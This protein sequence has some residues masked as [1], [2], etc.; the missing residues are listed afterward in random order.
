V[1]VLISTAASQT[2]VIFPEG[3]TSSDPP[4]CGQLRGG[5]FLW[6]QS[7]TWMKNTADISTNMYNLSLESSLGYN[8]TG[9]YGFDRIALGGIGSGGLT[10]VNQTI[11]GIEY[12]N[13]FLGLFGLNPRFSTFGNSKD[14]IPSFLVNLKTQGLIPSTSWSYTAGNQYRE[15]THDTHSKLCKLRTYIRS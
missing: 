7:T 15:S 4:N 12:A 5:E 9:E 3:C 13:F 6:N 2:L 11:A 8:G 14:S 10:L 1:R